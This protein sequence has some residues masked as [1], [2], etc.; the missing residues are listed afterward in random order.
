M[1][2]R[3]TSAVSAGIFLLMLT[4]QKP[5]P[6]APGADSTETSKTK[7]VRLF[8][9]CRQCDMEYIRQEIK[10]VNHVRDRNQAQVEILIT[11][12]RTGN[13]GSEFTLTFLGREEFSGI[14]DTL[15][16]YTKQSDTEESIR[17][18]LLSKMKIGLMRYV[19][20][21]PAADQISISFTTAAQETAAVDRWDYWVFSINT[22]AFING[23]KSSSSLSLFGSLNA[24]RVTKDLKVNLSIGA[25]HSRN[26]FDYEDYSYESVSDGKNANGLVVV[27]LGDHW[28][29]G[30]TLSGY[31]STFDNTDHSF[32]AGPAIEYDVFPYSE[33]TR[34]QLRILYK[35]QFTRVR[36]V[37]TTLYGKLSEE[38]WNERISIS[39]DVKEP[40]GSAGVA[41]NGSHFFHDFGKYSIGLFGNLSL[42]LV[43]GLSLN[44]FGDYSRIHDQISITKGGAT[45]EE[46]LLQRRALETQYRY[47]VSV[48]L[49]YTF[50][51]IFNNVVNPRFG[52]GGGGYSISISN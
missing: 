19:A 24:N 44:L 21:S 14:N 30:G 9:D 17:K 51:S 52:S 2:S 31:S 49:S 45:Q 13:G 27:S 28:S 7:T 48:G 43:E 26:T 12:Q 20:K 22:N 32:S 5:A 42:R 1:I 39:L 6:A 16:S 33:S 34:R 46:V 10:F 40:W 11:T 36:Y 47:F 29:A 50:G 25:N 35:L 41:V 37:D 3:P 15:I 38:L 18:G 8:I 23:E 4:L